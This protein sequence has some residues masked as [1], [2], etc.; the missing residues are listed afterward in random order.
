MDRHPATPPDDV[1]PELVDHPRYRVL[2]LVGRG[3][4]GAVYRAEHRRMERLVALKVIHPR[5]T[6]HPAA[7]ERFQQEVR[8]AARLDH[9]NIVTAY[10]AD[11]AGGLHF[12]VMEYVEGTSLAEL[13]RRRGPLPVAEACDTPGR[14]RWACS[15]PTSR[16]WSTATSSRTTSCSRPRAGSRSSTSAWPACRA[17]PTL[18]R[19][20]A[21]G[22]SLT[23]AGT[24]MGTADYIA[25]EQAAD[26]H[27]ADIRADIY[28]LGCTLFHLLTGRPPFPSGTVAEKLARHA[29]DAAA[30]PR[31]RP[32]IPARPGRRPRPHDGEG[33]GRPLRARPAEVAQ[34]IDPVLPAEAAIASTRAAGRGD[35]SLAVGLVPVGPRASRLRRDRQ[36]PASSSEG[37]EPIERPGDA[38]CVAEKAEGGGGEGGAGRRGTQGLGPPRRVPPRASRSPSSTWPGPR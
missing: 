30:L 23:G 25:P 29:D 35:W 7:V 16:G 18:I 27:A 6:S 10:D 38:G 32:G 20:G 15:T 14:R 37:D 24:V 4:M 9:P 28:S 8:A 11:Q 26:P 33:A 31:Q 13:R 1:P 2:G 34:R 17:T 22:G 21:A 12:L 19:G 5:L 36:A 3:G